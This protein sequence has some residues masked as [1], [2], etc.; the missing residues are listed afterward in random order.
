VNRP[1]IWLRRAAGLV[2]AACAG[3]AVSIAVAG[4]V[5]AHGPVPPGAPDLGAFLFDWSL[6]PLVAVPLTMAGLAWLALVDRIN[7]LHPERPVSRWRTAA[8]FA[9]LASIAIALLSGVEAYDTTLF[10]VHMVQHMLLTF[11]AAPLLLLAAPITQLLRAASPEV[12]RRWILPLLHSKTVAVVGHPVV[13]WLVFTVVMWATHFSPLFDLALEDRGVHDLEHALFLGSALL[14]WWPLV[15]ADPGPRRMG[16]PARVL[17]LLLQMPP[18]SFLA[19][20]ILMAGAPLYPH[21]ATL[22][23]PYGIDAL[24]DQQLAAGLMWVM[25]DMVFIGA[26]LLVVAAWMRREE[27]DA[28][29]AERRAERERERINERAEAL[30]ARGR[31][32]GERP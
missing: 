21:Y 8:F 26:I 24:A 30:A 13:A 15:G 31:Q 29:A 5:A 10:S 23:S 1:P 9:G 17:S 32:A 2:A 3:A 14:F 16:Y 25:S 6:E 22:G 19:V 4:P 12:R 20:A 7:R 28:P 27:L 18:S 11:A